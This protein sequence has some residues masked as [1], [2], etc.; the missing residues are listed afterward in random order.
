MELIFRF[1]EDLTML[2]PADNRITK[3][4][5]QSLSLPDDPVILDIG[6]GKGRQTRI[7]ADAKPDSRIVPT[8]VY[9]PYLQAIRDIPGTSPVCGTM[10]N[11]P[12]KEDS[13][14]LIWSEGAINIMGFSQGITAWKP[15]LKD[16]GYLA[17]SEICWHKSNP[18][19]DLRKFWEEDS[20]G[21]SSE[22]ERIRDAEAAG[23]TITSTIRLP[24]KAWEDY[25]Q[26]VETRINE[27]RKRSPDAETASF[28]DTMEREIEIFR[29]YGSYYGYTF[30]ILKKV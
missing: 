17:I 11:L 2:G 20:P 5:L 27:W 29:I 7:L 18:P 24:M 14:D 10:D 21:T 19:E 28:L 22:E 12:F 26:P 30:F 23:Y 9:I 8:D 13:I 16:G 4:I 1:F 6:S 15:L 3:E 25:Y